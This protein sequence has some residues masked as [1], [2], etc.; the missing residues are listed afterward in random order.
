VKQRKNNPKFYHCRFCNYSFSVFKDTIFE[1]TSTDLIKWLYAI[2]LFLND[3]KGI[4]AKQLQHEIGVTYKCAWRILKQVRKAMQEENQD[5]F[6]EAM[7]EVDE[8]YIGGKPRKGNNRNDDN[9]PKLK[10]GRGTSKT[11]VIGIVPRDD[12]KV[13]AKVFMPNKKGKSLTGLQILMVFNKVVKKMLDYL[14]IFEIR[15][16]KPPPR[17]L[18]VSDGFDDWRYDD[19]IDTVYLSPRDNIQDTIKK[20]V[21][22]LKL[23]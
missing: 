19:Y 20:S 9:L 11:P 22:L 5:G 12:K 14:G 6:Y 2:H 21:S 3:K 1:K 16:E 13:Y 18:S 15:K 17:I 4:S 10:P 8:T 23:I 7:I